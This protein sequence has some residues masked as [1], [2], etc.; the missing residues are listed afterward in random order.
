MDT[1]PTATVISRL[2][3]ESNRAYDMR[4]RYVTM[5]PSRSIDKVAAQEDGKR[6]ARYIQRW[7][8]QFDWAATA[9]AWDDQRAAEVA[10]Q[11]AEDYRKGIEDYRERYSKS[12]RGLHALASAYMNKLGQRIKDLDSS[13][14]TPG[15][16]ALDVRT[17]ASALQVAGDLEAHA[18]GIDR[19]LQQFDEGQP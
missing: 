10:A 7:S 16:L 17:V 4:V 15:R 18:L 1:T 14:I 6:A 8:Q 2:E 19:L 9:R 11:A 13:E 3:G 12:G 5:G